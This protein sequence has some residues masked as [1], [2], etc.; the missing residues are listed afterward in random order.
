MAFI[1][2][3]LYQYR[4]HHKGISQQSSKENAKYSFTKAI[5]ETMKRRGIKIIDN[6]DVP[7]QFTNAEEIYQLLQYQTE[8]LFRIRNKIK[9]YVTSEILIVFL[10]RVP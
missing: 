2:E 1:A 4:Q 6:K 8:P 7:D 10:L 5:H 3:N 9:F